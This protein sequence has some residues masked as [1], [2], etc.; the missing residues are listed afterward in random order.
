MALVYKV[1]WEGEDDH[2]VPNDYVLSSG[3]WFN[4]DPHYVATPV[5]DDDTGR[6]WWFDAFWL[7]SLIV[8]CG[9]SCSRLLFNGTET[10]L[11]S[12]DREKST[13]TN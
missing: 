4:T 1:E 6:S 13:E 7:S 11:L 9:G 10:W 5:G 12:V 2:H 8:I 3:K